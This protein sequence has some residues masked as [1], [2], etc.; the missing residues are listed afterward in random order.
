MGGSPHPNPPKQT[1]KQQQHDDY[2]NTGFQSI[3]TN[4]DIAYLPQYVLSTALEQCVDWCV[5][6]AAHGHGQECL[7]R[8]GAG[9]LFTESELET[10]IERTWDYPREIPLVLRSMRARTKFLLATPT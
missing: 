1:N 5:A 8:A 9:E 7:S 3:A 6:N 10:E 4:L 2:S